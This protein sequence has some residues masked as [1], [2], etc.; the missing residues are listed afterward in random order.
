M[1][2][3]TDILFIALAVFKTYIIIYRKT[4]KVKK[5]DLIEI[6]NSIKMKIISNL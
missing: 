6:K 5:N 3:L 4:Q 2:S 1:S